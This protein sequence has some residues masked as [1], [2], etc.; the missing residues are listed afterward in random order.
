MKFGNLTFV[1]AKE[2]QEL[3]PVPVRDCLE[4]TGLW[5]EVEVAE[6]DPGLADTAAFCDHYG[7]G[8][9]VSAN[10]VVMQARRGERTT[11][12]ACV[13][14]ATT[15]ADVNGIIK[16]QVDARK[17]SFASMDAAVSLTGMEYGGITPVG[18]PADWVLLI[19]AQVVEHERLIIGSGT[20]GS[21]LLVTSKLLRDLPGAVIMDITK[22]A[23]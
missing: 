13:V 14:L 5:D 12:V 3:L 17:I 9:D 18:V 2:A 22:P 10:C 8:L 11:F 21:K 15:R 19:D 16:K 7:I 20:R 1:H 4:K 6:I 23:E